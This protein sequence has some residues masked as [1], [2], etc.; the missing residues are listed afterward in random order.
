MKK[1]YQCCVLV[2]V[3]LTN[4]N[5]N[6]KADNDFRFQCISVIAYTAT[7]IKNN[8]GYDLLPKMNAIGQQIKDDLARDYSQEDILRVSMK[9][10]QENN[11]LLLNGNKNEFFKRTAPCE[12]YLKKMGF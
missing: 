4:L 2:A 10:H 5:A 8:G 1:L 12:N 6:Q 3:F 9:V 11:D 7:I